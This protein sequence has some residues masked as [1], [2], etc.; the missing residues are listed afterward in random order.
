MEKSRRVTKTTVAGQVRSN[1]KLSDALKP[2]M[3]LSEREMFHFDGIVSSR[4]ADSWFPHHLTIA[5]LLAK[6]IARMEKIN[7][8]LDI[9]GEMAESKRGTPVVHPLLNASM[10]L[11]NTIQALTRTL[12]LS[13]SVRGLS[14]V[15]QEKRNKADKVAREAIQKAAEDALLA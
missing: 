4:E 12:G 8:Q 6:S 9:E 13:A 11:S 10:S 3:P 5:C 7:Q 14:D 2:T 15:H 1:M